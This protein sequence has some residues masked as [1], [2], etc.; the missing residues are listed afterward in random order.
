MPENALLDDDDAP[1]AV[2]PFAVAP[3]DD[4]LL[5]VDDAPLDDDDAP[6]DEDAP[7]DNARFDA[8][9]GA[10]ITPTI[11]TSLQTPFCFLACDLAGSTICT[12]L[13]SLSLSSMTLLFLLFAARV[14]TGKAQS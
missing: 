4:A 12:S 1:F 7:L 8:G 2:V 13:S 9:F 6:F 14:T 10:G 11:C 5:L 3:L